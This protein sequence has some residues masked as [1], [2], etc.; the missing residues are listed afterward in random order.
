MSE[1]LSESTRSD[2]ADLV[3]GRVGDLISSVLEQN[4]LKKRELRRAIGSA[5]GAVIGGGTAVAGVAAGLDALERHWGKMTLGKRFAANVLASIP[6]VMM[7]QIGSRI[8]GVVG[9]KTASANKAES[10]LT[11][12][13]RLLKSRVINIVAKPRN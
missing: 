11:Q 12:L 1:T 9:E 2:Y 6:V 4:R 5:S 3:K 10:V 7:S 13:R 8:G